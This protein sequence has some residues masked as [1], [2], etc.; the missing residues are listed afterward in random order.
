MGEEGEDLSLAGQ[1]FPIPDSTAVVK[2]GQFLLQSLYEPRKETSKEHF[3]VKTQK[4]Y[5]R[6]SPARFLFFS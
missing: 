1:F 6:P 5:V 2:P 3:W 4:E